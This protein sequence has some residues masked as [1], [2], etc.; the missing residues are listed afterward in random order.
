[1][2]Q[3]PKPRETGKVIL[4]LHFTFHLTMLFTAVSTI[5]K[6]ANCFCVSSHLS[7]VLQERLLVIQKYHKGRLT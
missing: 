4:E 1:M 2:I 5:F 7:P 6:Q 3:N